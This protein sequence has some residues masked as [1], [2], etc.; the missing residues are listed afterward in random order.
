MHSEKRTTWYKEGAITIVTGFL[1][2]GSNTIVGHP[3]DTVKTKMQAQVG[4]MGD[5]STGIKAPGYIET[6]T[7]VYSSEGLVGFYR[8][9]MPPFAGSVI[10]R[11]AQFT[12]YEMFYTKMENNEGMK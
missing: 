6:I 7:K 2:G 4:H 5:K 1:Y 8:G 11:S 3:F 9:W 10:F 12:V